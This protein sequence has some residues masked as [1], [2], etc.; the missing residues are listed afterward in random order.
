[1]AIHEL[2]AATP[3][4]VLAVLGG[5]HGDELEGVTAARQVGQRL[6]DRPGGLVKGA[7][8]I[9]PV[10]N[11]PAFAARSRC[12]PVD[13]ANLARVFPGRPDGT[14]SERIAHVLTTEVIAGSDLL[15]DLHSAGAAFEMPVFAG[16]VADA[17]TAEEAGAAAYAFAAPVVWEHH[18]SGPGRSMSA[19]EDLGIPSIYV[20]GSGGGGLRGADLD[21]YVAGVLRLCAAYGVIEGEPDPPLEPVVL[22]GEAGDTDALI[23]ATAQGYCVTRVISG[24]VVLR[25]TVLADILDEDGRLT[26][27]VRAPRAGTVMMLR[28]GAEIAPGDGIAML[29]PTPQGRS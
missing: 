25:G 10:S 11:P 9:V 6:S 3:G 28:R 17:A 24:E 19:A 7:V 12:S 8:R 29:G 16:Y 15:V 21:V 22:R 1:M 2:R 13:G 26:Q 5:V 20:E 14:V 4:P 23:S 27:Q 18:G